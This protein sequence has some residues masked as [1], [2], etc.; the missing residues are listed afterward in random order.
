[1]SDVLFEGNLLQHSGGAISILGVDN[2]HPSGQTRGIVIRSNVF[3]DLDNQRWGGNGYAFQI[4]D[5]PRDITIDRNTIAQEH[6]AGFLQVEG[7]Q[8]PGFVFTNNIAKQLTYGIA[9]RDRAPGSDSLS[10]YFPGARVTGNVIADGDGGRFP[11]GNTFPS[12]QDVC[13]DPA[14]LRQRKDADARIPGQGGDAF[15]ERAVELICRGTP[16]VEQ[17]KQLRGGDERQRK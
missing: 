9:G 4:T 10:A 13:R 8:I 7:P 15:Q 17:W 12:W 3:A 11:R 5:G 2:H 1:V 16:L 14:S 6:G